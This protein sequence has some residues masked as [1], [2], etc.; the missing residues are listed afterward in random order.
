MSTGQPR[1]LSVAQEVRT[2]DD[3]YT[4]SFIFEA[5]GLVFDI[6][7]AA[8]P[9]GVPW[10]PCKRFFTMG[11]DGLSQPWTGRVWMNPPYSQTTPWV[12]RFIE[13]GNGVALVQHA[14]AQWH[15]TLWA[16]ADAVAFPFE[17]F[18]FV[19]GEVFMPVWFAAFGAECVEAL[20]RVGVV[21]T[22]HQSGGES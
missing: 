21:R 2:K 4:P 12:R 15:Q 10:V 20:S 16:T 1:L 18:D 19:G 6:D 17:R 14:K 7:V 11:D 3:Y 13:H 9:G 22:M 5:L 8:P